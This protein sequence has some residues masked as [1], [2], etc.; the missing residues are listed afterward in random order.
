MTT[1][2]LP[3][4]DSNQSRTSSLYFTYFRDCFLICFT[5]K[6]GGHRT[7]TDKLTHSLLLIIFLWHPSYSRRIHMALLF[8]NQLIS[9]LGLSTSSLSSF[10]YI[11][12]STLST[13]NHVSLPTPS[14]AIILS[15]FNVT[16]LGL[17]FKQCYEPPISLLSFSGTCPALK[18]THNDQQ[19]ILKC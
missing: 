11:L 4:E 16:P 1:E 2:T 15:T 10:C 19:K 3:T 12:S 13:S 9:H 14:P 8:Q 6:L 17:L 7:I 5:Q 18:W